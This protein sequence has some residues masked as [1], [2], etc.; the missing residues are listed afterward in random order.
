MGGKVSRAKRMCT[1]E[2]TTK[3]SVNVNS[4]V[5]YST[6]KK[7]DTQCVREVLENRRK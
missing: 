2:R 4:G 1:E 6:V 5:D 7:V 3:A